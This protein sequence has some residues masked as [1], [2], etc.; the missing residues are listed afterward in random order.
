MDFLSGQMIEF[1]F[2]SMQHWFKKMLIL[3][4]SVCSV[5][6]FLFVLYIV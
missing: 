2:Y 1:L 3:T 4:F 6:E 5:F